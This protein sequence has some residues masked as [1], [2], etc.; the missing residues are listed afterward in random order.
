MAALLGRRARAT[1]ACGKRR[2]FPRGCDKN[3]PSA[4]SAFLANPRGLASSAFLA[5]DRFL[6]Q[7]GSFCLPG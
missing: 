5:Y 6:S 3:R 7:R 4:A 2:P 1:Q